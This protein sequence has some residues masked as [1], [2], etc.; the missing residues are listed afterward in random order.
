M[1]I[2]AAPPFLFALV[3]P[4]A[5]APSKPTRSTRHSTAP[6]S[7]PTWTQMAALRDR[8]PTPGVRH[9]SP[10]QK[11]AQVKIDGALMPCV[12]PYALKSTNLVLPRPGRAPAA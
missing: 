2:A 9:M 4:A 3:V 12:A 8:C 10:A 1:R 7:R 6:S 11:D 5:I